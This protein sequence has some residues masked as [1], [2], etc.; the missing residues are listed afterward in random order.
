M[1][2][3][4]MGCSREAA[5][6]VVIKER[7]NRGVQRAQSGVGIDQSQRRYFSRASSIPFGLGLSG[8]IS[9][10]RFFWKTET[11]KRRGAAFGAN[12]SQVPGDRDF[13]SGKQT[14]EPRSSLVVATEEAARAASLLL[15]LLL[16]LRSRDT[17][18]GGLCSSLSRSLV[19]PSLVSCGI[20]LVV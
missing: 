3:H 13:S 11:A 5:S 8:G 12:H 7:T 16:K 15:V 1:Y 9:L 18:E 2:V 19:G 14:P 4:N 17:K 20:P 6:F 10:I